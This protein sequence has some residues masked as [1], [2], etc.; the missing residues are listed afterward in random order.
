MLAPAFDY[1]ATAKSGHHREYFFPDHTDAADALVSSAGDDQD[2]FGLDDLSRSEPR[3]GACA[4]LRCSGKRFPQIESALAS[5][6]CFIQRVP[7][8][9]KL[10][11]VPAHR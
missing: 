9:G 5:K 10:R 6:R 1:T 8:R 4:R 7:Q 2:F 3:I 11:F